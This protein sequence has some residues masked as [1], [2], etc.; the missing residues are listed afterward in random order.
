[1][2]RIPD[3]KGL[4]VIIDDEVI[5]LRGLKVVVEGW[6]YEVIM[7]AS[8]VEAMS[9]LDERPHG[10][11]LIIADYRLRLGRTGVQA[12]RTSGPAT[13]TGQSPAF[14]SRATRTRIDC[15]RPRRAAIACSTSPSHHLSCGTCWR[16]I[17]QS[18]RPPDVKSKREPMKSYGINY[19]T[20]WIYAK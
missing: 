17:V 18:D 5:I 11:D 10:P 8:E 9:Q 13:A 16:A 7:A 6:G 4:V 2:S 12:I 1:M 14:S 20:S 19:A 3:G 15:R